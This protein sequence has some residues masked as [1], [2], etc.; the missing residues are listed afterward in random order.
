MDIT[1]IHRYLSGEADAAEKRAFEDWLAASDENRAKFEEYRKIYVVSIEQAQQFDAVSALETFRN[2]RSEISPKSQAPRSTAG[3]AAVRLPEN[4]RASGLWLKIAA[5]LLLATGISLY[6]L[7][8]GFTGSDSPASQQEAGSWYETGFGEQRSYRLPDGSRI[9]LNADSRLFLPADYGQQNRFVRLSGEG[10]FEVETDLNLPFIVQTGE[11]EVQVLGTSFGVRARPEQQASVVAVQSGR[12]A[13]QS[14][15]EASGLRSVELGA[16]EY[17]IV[18]AGGEPAAPSTSGIRQY[19][20]WH[21][22][23]F[24]FRDTPLHEMLAQ[25]E[26]HFN[27]HITLKDSSSIA[28]PVTARYSTE[29]LNEILDITS[30]THGVRFEVTPRTTT[31]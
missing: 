25:L 21:K 27:V 10:F 11:A 6:V 8:P 20:S 18:P 24:V 14:A 31:P 3:R 23:K 13:V 15:G 1:Q 30:L 12:V 28:E 5:L 2:N 22:Q 4:R 7:Y 9:R 29:S 17:T 26:R 16:G 19:L